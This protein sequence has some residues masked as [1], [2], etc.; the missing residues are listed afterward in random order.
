MTT[1][2]PYR[3]RPEIVE[4]MQYDGS[5][6]SA[7]AIGE[8]CAMD[9]EQYSDALALGSR[10]H[11]HVLA[12]GRWLIRTGS[13]AFSVCPYLDAVCELVPDAAETERLAMVAEDRA[14]KYDGHALGADRDGDDDVAEHYR[15]LAADLRAIA[16]M[17]REGVRA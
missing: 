8:W 12:V 1:P 5:E 9:Y 11:G 6:E 15:E 13:G 7:R 2:Q 10:I 17:L 16:A 4:A 3:R 14:R